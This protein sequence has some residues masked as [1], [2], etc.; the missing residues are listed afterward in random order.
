M[1]YV[2]VINGE[3]SGYV[4]IKL[5]M[6]NIGIALHRPLWLWF[7]GT[8]GVAYIT[9]ALVLTPKIGVASFMVSVVAGQMLASLFLDYMGIM[10]LAT[11]S[12]GWGKLIGVALI[13]MGMLFVQMS[14]TAYVK[15]S[16]F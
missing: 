2:S 11:R 1:E 5:P 13:I 12:I 7:G 4:A 10:D 9:A 15:Q 6:Q 3:H 8:A 14:N 16:V